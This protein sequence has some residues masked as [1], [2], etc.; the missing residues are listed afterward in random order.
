MDNIYYSELQKWFKSYSLDGIAYSLTNKDPKYT[1]RIN[2]FH[3]ALNTYTFSVTSDDMSK[4][5]YDTQEFQEVC[6]S[7]NIGII[8]DMAVIFEKYLF[9]KG[10]RGKVQIAQILD[11]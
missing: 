9:S 7:R 3:N 11:D 10:Y 6:K 4:V 1:I 5:I 2:V 8:K